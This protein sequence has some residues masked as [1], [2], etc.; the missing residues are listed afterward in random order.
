[1]V[2]KRKAKKK[3]KRKKT[4]KRKMRFVVDFPLPDPTGSRL[5]W[6]FGP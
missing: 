5:L 3:P 2:K 6:P 4:A 1:M